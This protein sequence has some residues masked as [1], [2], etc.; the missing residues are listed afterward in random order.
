MEGYCL[1]DGC[2]SPS[3]F[4]LH[5]NWL[6]HAGLK[7]PQQRT[8]WPISVWSLPPSVLTLG[9]SKANQF[10]RTFRQ[11]VFLRFLM[12]SSQWRHSS[13]AFFLTT[14]C[15]IWRTLSNANCIINVH[16]DLLRLIWKNCNRI[17]WLLSTKWCYFQNRPAGHSCRPWGPLRVPQAPCLAPVPGI[18]CTSSCPLCLCYCCLKC[19]Y[20]S[21]SKQ[22]WAAML[23][24]QDKWKT[25]LLSSA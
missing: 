4:T 16:L 23:Q 11:T 22:R 21:V 5:T 19:R 14:Q 3:L 24:L 12:Y 2:D 20:D 10:V 8:D 25:L 7:G 13:F 9:Y 15:C 1:W 6:T 17:R 18:V